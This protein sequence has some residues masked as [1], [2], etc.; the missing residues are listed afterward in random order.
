MCVCVCV[1]VC[2]CGG[3]GGGGGGASDTGFN[4]VM[5]TIRVSIISLDCLAKS[6]TM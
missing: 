4:P 6:S 2:V 5:T 3:G 1:C